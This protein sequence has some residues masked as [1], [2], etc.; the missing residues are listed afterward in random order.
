MHRGRI[1]LHGVGLWVICALH[2][3]G[4]YSVPGF[5]RAGLGQEDI[6]EWPVT[7]QAINT[8]S[9]FPS[10]AVIHLFFFPLQLLWQLFL[11]F[12]VKKCVRGHT[13]THTFTLDGKMTISAQVP[14]HI[15]SPFIHVQSHIGKEY[16]VDSPVSI[17][18]SASSRENIVYAMKVTFWDGGVF[19]LGESCSE[20]LIF[21][22][23]AMLWLATPLGYNLV[24]GSSWRKVK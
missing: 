3:E 11:L 4:L 22:S 7:L 18:L 17:L 16:V 2:T 20:T 6:Q 24:T 14:I 8:L 1:G 23:A 5:F 15:S 9:P 12:H 19:A 21:I 13:H 10:A